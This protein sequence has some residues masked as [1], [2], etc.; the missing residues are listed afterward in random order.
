MCV[1]HSMQCA[2]SNPDLGGLHRGC[3]VA[4]GKSVQKQYGHGACLCCRLCCGF[5]TVHPNPPPLLHLP[6]FV[7]SNGK[8]GTGQARDSDICLTC[9]RVGRQPGYAS[10]RRTWKQ[11]QV[12]CFRQHN[13]SEMCFYP[14]VHS[15]QCMHAHSAG[16]QPG[17]LS[18]YRRTRPGAEQ[19]RS[20]WCWRLP[21]VTV[22]LGWQPLPTHRPLC[23]AVPH[24]W[25]RSQH[26]SQPPFLAPSSAAFWGS[27]GV[28][29]KDGEEEG[30]T[31]QKS[32]RGMGS[33]S[34]ASILCV[35]LAA[36][37]QG[38]F[39]MFYVSQF[40][41]E[42]ALSVWLRISAAPPGGKNQN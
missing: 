26:C 10:G 25:R 30:K 15:E 14:Q 29:G 11:F 42:D 20:R 39:A 24:A 22:P 28:V 4:A 2:W 23:R 27:A 17:Y 36:F 19:W 41:K 7:F 5:G 18:V 31:S 32:R 35:L 21:D 34:C 8:M 9:H 38:L 1:K 6:P 40:H 33:A 13:R 37:L 3:I 12:L 16:A